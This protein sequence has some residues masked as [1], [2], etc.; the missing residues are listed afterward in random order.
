MEQVRRGLEQVTTISFPQGQK[1]TEIVTGIFLSSSEV[2]AYVVDPEPL[3]E[4]SQR[5]RIV[6]A[7]TKEFD[8]GMYQMHNAKLLSFVGSYSQALRIAGLKEPDRYVSPAYGFPE[9]TL[10][11]DSLDVSFVGRTFILPQT[12][13]GDKPIEVFLGYDEVLSTNL[14]AG[15]MRDSFGPLE[16]SENI[17]NILTENETKFLAQS[18]DDKSYVFS[19]GEDGTIIRIKQK[20]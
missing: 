16:P 9:E 7:R 17:R 18:S 4:E 12:H 11:I 15:R 1:A 10:S 19:I 2:V 14:V 5:E 20:D 3:D 6:V 8:N 13:S